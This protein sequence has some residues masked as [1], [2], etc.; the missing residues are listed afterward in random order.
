MRKNLPELLQND[1][2]YIMDRP[3]RIVLVRH[4]ESQRNE[5]KSRSVYFADDAARNRLRGIPDHKIKLTIEGI[6]QALVTGIQLR[7]EFG[8]FDYIYH[9]GYKRT[10]ETLDGILK[11]YNDE[12]K[13]KMKIR[14]DTDL[15]ERDP[16]Y[17]YD[18]TVEEAE[19]A[20]PWLQKYWNT[21]G[22]IMS[23]PPGGESLADVVRRVRN[24]YETILRNRRIGDNVLVICHGGVIRSFRWL[25]QLSQHHGDFEW[26]DE[27]GPKNCS[28]TPYEYNAETGKLVCTVYNKIYY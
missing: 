17:A 5:A 23:R 28:V 10:Q 27:E 3:K 21:F 19:N 8:V 22:P 26:I 13:E 11:A 7:E 1:I 24:F 6:R 9:S 18:M 15:R 4:A 20:F 16:G 25:F 12:E 14:R 2:P